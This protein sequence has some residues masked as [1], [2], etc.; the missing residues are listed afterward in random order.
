[1]LQKQKGSSSEIGAEEAKDFE[2]YETG[3]G[4]NVLILCTLP[5]SALIS[6]I[7]TEWSEAK[8]GG[9]S[10]KRKSTTNNNDDAVKRAK[11]ERQ[12][13]SSERNQKCSS[14]DI[15]ANETSES[16]ES[17]PWDPVE[18]VKRVI[19]DLHSKLTV[20]PSSRFVTRMIPIQATCFASLEEIGLTAKALVQKYLKGSPPSTFAVNVKRRNCSTVTRDEIIDVVAGAMMDV[21]GNKNEWKV[22]LSIPSYTILVEICKTLCGM[23]IVKNAG[24][25]IKYR[26]F[27]LLEIREAQEAP[28]DRE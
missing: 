16:D 20:A 13:E 27:N 25:S 28:K 9:D 15:A 12:G 14:A 8:E 17:P 3:C 10:A 7:Q 18:T 22:N 4:G 19:H 11:I 5:D 6:P 2:V 1:M 24:A 26:N 23:T 21:E